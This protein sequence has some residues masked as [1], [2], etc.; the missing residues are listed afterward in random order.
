MHE[1]YADYIGSRVALDSNVTTTSL[2]FGRN[3]EDPPFNVRVLL[4]DTVLK[5]IY[6]LLRQAIQQREEVAGAKIQVR[7][8][9]MQKMGIAPEDL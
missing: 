5:E 2:F 7:E 8:S 9:F 4:P 3:G 6:F 1:Y